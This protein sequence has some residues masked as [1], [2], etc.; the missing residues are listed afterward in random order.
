M[1]KILILYGT[2][3]GHT[4]KIAHYIAGVMASNGHDPTIL[5]GKTLPPDF[6]PQRF[7]AAIIG[8]SLHAGK[9]QGYIRDFIRANLAWLERV[10]S[11]FFSVSL[12]VASRKEEDRLPARRL[13]E[14]F[15]RETGWHPL[16]IETIAGALLYTQYGFLIRRIMK[17]IARKAG[18]DTDTSRDYVY[19]DWQAVTAFAEECLRHLAVPSKREGDHKRLP[20]TAPTGVVSSRR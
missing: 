17:G 20:P 15:M 3:D 4:A 16:Q 5:C 7:D 13:A 1:A 11:A 18:G 8:A 6:A 9:H 12:A 14:E 19:T 2:T 10:P